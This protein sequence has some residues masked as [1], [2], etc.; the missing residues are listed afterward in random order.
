MMMSLSRVKVRKNRE[1]LFSQSG[2]RRRRASPSRRAEK[3]E[4]EERDSFLMRKE[5][6]SILVVVLFFAFTA[7]LTM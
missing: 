6:D 7:Q 3:T 1:V 2:T 4:K 5:R